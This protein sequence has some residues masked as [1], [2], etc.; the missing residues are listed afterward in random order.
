MGMKNTERTSAHYRTQYEQVV[1]LGIIA[2]GSLFF[3]YLNH[4]LIAAQNLPIALAIHASLAISFWL[5]WKVESLRRLKLELCLFLTV[6]VFEASWFLSFYLLHQQLLALG[7]ILMWM[8]NLLL[9]TA[10]FWKK[11]K[12]AG[13]T[14]SIVLIWTFYLLSTNIMLCITNP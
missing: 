10:L 3:T 13:L 9:L 11:D 1:G 4:L 5:L 2:F 8:T 14:L 7:F 6:F 12:M